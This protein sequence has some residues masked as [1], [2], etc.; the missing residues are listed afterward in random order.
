MIL[1]LAGFIDSGRILCFRVICLCE[2]M[3]AD[4]VLLLNSSFAFCFDGFSILIRHS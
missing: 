4:N 3:I 1:I 2:G